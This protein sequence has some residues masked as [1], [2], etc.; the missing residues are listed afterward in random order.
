MAV[1]WTSDR[2]EKLLMLV[3]G[4]LQVNKDQLAKDWASAYPDEEFQPTARALVEQFKVLQ[5]RSGAKGSTGG[6]KKTFSTPKSTPKATPVSKRTTTN[7][8]PQSRKRAATAMSDDDDDD[9]DDEKFDLSTP[10][11]KRQATSRRSKS[12]TASYVDP[13]S[14]GEEGAKDANDEQSDDGLDDA[15]ASVKAGVQDKADSH[16]P[17]KRDSVVN[18]D[19]GKGKAAAVRDYMAE[20]DNDISDF[21]PQA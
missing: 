17:Q 5:K 21:N 16:D 4:G 13:G 1:K 9:D 18:S 6:A 2:N 10:L 11:P 14:S 8:T 12:R 3:I 7:K 20:E 15:F 19:G